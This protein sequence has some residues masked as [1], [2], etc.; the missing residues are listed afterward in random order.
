LPAFFFSGYEIIR[1]NK[2]EK[3]LEKVYLSQLDAILFSLNQ[4]SEDILLNTSTKL[5]SEI[6]LSQKL[7][8]S[9]IKDILMESSFINSVFWE[10]DNS[11]NL[12]Y[13]RQ[14]VSDKYYIKLAQ[15]LIE[16]NTNKINKLIDYYKIGYYKVE[17][18][19]QIKNNS[20]YIFA[21]LFFYKNKYLPI[22]I[23][24]N[25]SIFVSTVLG[26]KI[27]STAGEDL[28]IKVIDT[29]LN[30]D[31][32]T[33]G[34]LKRKITF[35]VIRP[36]W[37]F[38]HLQVAIAPN[39]FTASSL[40]KEQNR[41]NLIFIIIADILFILTA[42]IIL[43]NIRKELELS[44][45]KSDF[46]TN[47]SHEIRTPL[48]LISMYAET[49]FLNRIKD[50]KKKTEYY[51]IIFNESQRLSNIVNRIL[52]FSKIESG[53]RN[54]NYKEININELINKIINTF[55]YDLE[56]KEFFI[57][58]QLNNDLP[59]INADEEAIGEALF[60]LI[61]NAIKY[62]EK[63]KYL[64]IKSYSEDG[65]VCIEI[66]DKGNGIPTSE[67]KNIFDKFYRISK[68]DLAYPV[69]GN[70]LGLTIVKSIIESHGGQINV[71]SELN[72][73]SIFIVYLP[74]NNN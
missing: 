22:F 26:P 14:Y 57:D 29:E 28:T 31:I 48:A 52:S 44:R 16:E 74:F 69:K 30:K 34:N 68:G 72:K 67:Q 56:Q 20:H 10:K 9:T 39:T 73:G 38:P 53:K 59:S 35:K 19:G 51:N 71:K 50:D 13:G 3:E 46:V 41:K 12:C 37:M 70:G 2:N 66:K 5:K 17:R 58:I 24:I 45:L 36:M 4:Y 61:D 33:Y 55:R 54:F 49:L 1:F 7:Q 40:S 21:F 64:G 23:D 42:I 27:Q 32:L 43:V 63:G 60:N 62:C 6:Y 11:F 25:P 47:V 65:K 15:N 8:C 18:I